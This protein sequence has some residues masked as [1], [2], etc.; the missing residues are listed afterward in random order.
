MARRTIKNLADLISVATNDHR[1][2][3]VSGRGY[4]IWIRRYIAQFLILF[5][6]FQIT[7]L[8]APL[9]NIYLSGAMMAGI[10]AVIYFMAEFFKDSWHPWIKFFLKLEF[11]KEVDMKFLNQI[12]FFFLAF[13][14]IMIYASPLLKKLIYAKKKN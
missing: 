8:L 9:K 4:T 14:F 12:T 10:W 3:I 5:F 7:F 11:I 2:F 1:R 13:N 6:I